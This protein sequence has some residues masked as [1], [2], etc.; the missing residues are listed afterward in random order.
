MVDSGV[1]GIFNDFRIDVAAPC[2]Y[3]ALLV[4]IK[5]DLP[6]GRYGSAGG[7]IFIKKPLDGLSVFEMG[8]ND[9]LTMFFLDP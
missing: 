5:W 9:L 2:Q 4:G 3:N 7:R 6:I 1:Y 8:F